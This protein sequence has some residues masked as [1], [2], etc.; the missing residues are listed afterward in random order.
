[1]I[2]VIV[3]YNLYIHLIYFRILLCSMLRFH[4]SSTRFKNW[5]PSLWPQCTSTCRASRTARKSGG[6]ECRGRTPVG[7]GPRGAGNS[8]PERSKSGGWT[9]DSESSLN[10]VQFYSSASRTFSPPT[11]VVLIISTPK[12]ANISTLLVNLTRQISTF[13]LIF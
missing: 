12:Y 5:Q 1:M 11:L 6:T 13:P 2:K 7:P 8:S 4:Y 9:M 10:E 3:Y